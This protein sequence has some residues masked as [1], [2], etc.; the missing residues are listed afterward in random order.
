MELERTSV[1]TLVD[2]THITNT[3][4]ER[5]TRDSMGRIRTE[6]ESQNELGR[7]GQTHTNISV[8][9]PVAGESY[10]WQTGSYDQKRYMVNKLNQ[11]GAAS[12]HPVQAP[13]ISPAMRPA[14]TREKLGVQDVQ[15][16]SCDAMRTTTIYPVG[17][18]GNDRPLRS[19]YESC[20]SREFGR[21]LMEHAE[22]PRSGVS[23]TKL[24][25]ISRTE[26]EVSTFQPPAGYT[27][28]TIV[29]SGRGAGTVT[30]TP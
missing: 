27:P 2:G 9:D 17:Y 16:V 13:A 4:R 22:D 11:R 3:T 7:P 5:Y 10:S 18:M 15:G 28:Q 30:P 21:S 6:F 1:Q 20:M 8:I 29:D 24:L 25:S 23:D 26:P 12:V 19:V 14:L